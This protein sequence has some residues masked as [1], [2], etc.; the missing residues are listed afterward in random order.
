MKSYFEAT[1]A[2]I[3]FIANVSKISNKSISIMHIIFMRTTNRI[4]HCLKSNASIYHKNYEHNKSCFTT[5]L[6]SSQN[7]KS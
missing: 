7:I 4:T 2:S 5:F 6:K 3:V 1:E